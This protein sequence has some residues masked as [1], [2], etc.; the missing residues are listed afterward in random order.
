MTPPMLQSDWPKYYNHG[1]NIVTPSLRLGVT[2]WGHQDSNPVDPLALVSNYY[3]SKWPCPFKGDLLS[4][5]NCTTT[6]VY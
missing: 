3:M 2:G 1:T 4:V 5:H 6:T